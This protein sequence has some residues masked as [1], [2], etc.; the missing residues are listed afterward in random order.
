MVAS[1]VLKIE[2]FVNTVEWIDEYM[3]S[4]TQRKVHNTSYKSEQPLHSNDCPLYQKL[5]LERQG[6]IVQSPPVH[7]A[8][9]FS[10][11]KGR[12]WA[13]HRWT[14]YVS[15]GNSHCLP[16]VSRRMREVAWASGGEECA[17]NR[18]DTARGSYNLSHTQITH[19]HCPTIVS[20][21]V[22]RK[23]KP[24]YDIFNIL[25]NWEK[26]RKISHMRETLD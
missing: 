10:A 17:G 11:V 24:S 1:P 18:K 12:F 23:I 7:V 2:P 22:L 21:P 25:S 16:V 13:N 8:A 3:R 20:D 9:M 6:K 4:R 26:L 14:S 5:L 19:G 15:H